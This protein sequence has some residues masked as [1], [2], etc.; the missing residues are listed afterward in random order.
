MF[1]LSCLLFVQ[2][3]KKKILG[4]GVGHYLD[5]Q[6]TGL[7]IW[8]RKHPRNPEVTI[9]LMDTEV[10]KNENGFFFFVKNTFV[11]DW[12][13]RIFQPGTIGHYLQLQL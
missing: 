10:F 9:I 13:H 5:A 3:Q 12:I 4:F 8:A 6:T 2:Q 11:R 7:W 1:L